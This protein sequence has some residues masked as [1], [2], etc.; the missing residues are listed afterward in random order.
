MIGSSPEDAREL[1]KR[2]LRRSG[3]LCALRYNDCYARGAAPDTKVSGVTAW[4]AFLHQHRPTAHG[5]IRSV[6]SFALII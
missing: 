2:L 1:S 5:I 3:S 6:C 4:R